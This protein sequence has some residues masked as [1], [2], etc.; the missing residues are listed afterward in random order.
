MQI[1]LEQYENIQNYLDGRMTPQEENDFLIRLE[2]DISL[3]ENFE[4]EK[5]L[6][7]NLG[8]IL[9]KKNLFE[10]ESI[11]NDTDK[12]FK[13][14]DSIKSLIENAGNE[15]E[16]ENKEILHPVT[17]NIIGTKHKQQKTKFISLQSWIIIAAAACIVI[18]IISLV[19]FIQKPSSTVLV[20]TNENPVNRKDSN[21]NIAKTI[22]NDS[23]KNINPQTHKVN[24][25]ALFK[26]YYRKDTANPAMPELLA[27]VSEKY[28]N[29]DY[30]FREINL[31]K[32][33]LTRGSSND[34]NTRQNILQLGHY[35]KGLSYIET[36]DDKKAIENLQWVIENA[37]SEKI[38]IKAQWY[39]ALIYFKNDE[40]KKAISLLS[41]ISKNDSAAPYNKNAHDIL[42]A[43][44]T[45][46]NH[47]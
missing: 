20:K 39:L 34:I 46:Q 36:N 2:N 26:K 33:P 44:G 10:K 21:S 14:T 18:A 6:R 30:S 37:N 42:L 19:W 35:Y 9:D 31:D 25:A 12:D 32:V 15:W 24:Y 29:G 45:T 11:Y 28:K 41:S 13:D 17:E 22:P 3:N 38:K 1:T 47:N 27:M 5:E 40:N 23:I 8:S 4:F 16:Q 7:Q 43:I